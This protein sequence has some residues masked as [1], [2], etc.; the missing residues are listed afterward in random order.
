[1]IADIRDIAIIFLALESIVVLILLS[2]LIIQLRNLVLLLNREI[3]PMLSATRETADTVRH[4]TTFVSQHI[5]KPA[6]DALSFGAGVRQGVRTLRQNL[7]RR[8]HE[9]TTPA[10]GSEGSQPASTAGG[11]HE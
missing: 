1:M 6:I 3:K 9:A 8:D 11:N 7:A 5:A 2:I 4:T 10:A